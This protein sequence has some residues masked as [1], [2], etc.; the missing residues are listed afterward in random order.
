M[1]RNFFIIILAILSVTIFQMTTNA[2]AGEYDQGKSL[3][4]SKC[5]ICHGADG[6][7][8]GPAAA[9]LNPSPKDFDRPQ[10]WQGDVDQKITDTVRNG[11]SPMPAFDLSDGEIKAIIDYMKHAFKSK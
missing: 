7:G 1:K 4:D 2:W 11:H 8:N 3:Y 10:F 5:V 9:A 6:K